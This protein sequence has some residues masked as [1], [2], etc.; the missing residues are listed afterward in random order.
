[1]PSPRPATTSLK[2]HP[3]VWQKALELADG[4]S[5]RLLPQQEEDGSVSVVIKNHPVR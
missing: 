1:M 4:D 2:P 3:L 5:R